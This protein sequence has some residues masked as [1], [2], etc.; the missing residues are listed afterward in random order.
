MTSGSPAKRAALYARVSTDEQAAKGTSLAGQLERCRTHVQAAGWHEVGTF[1]DEGVSGALASRPALDQVLRLVED[2]EIDIVVITKLDRIARSLRHLLD[3][4]ELFESHDVGLVALDDP[5]DPST[6]SGRAMVQLRGVFAELERQ[7]IRER[8]MEGMLR[9]ATAGGW[10]GG[11][12]P[13]GYRSVDNPQGQGKVLAINE[14]EA[15]VIRL[16]YELIAVQ[17]ATTSEAARELDQLGTRPRRASHWTHSNLRRLLKDAEGISG[18]WP[19]RRGGRQ[20]RDST[21]EIIVEIPSI[22]TRE[23]HDQLLAVLATTSTVVERRRPYLLSGRI[24]SPHGLRMQGVPGN[25]D[26]R[27]YQ[28]PHV[29]LANVPDGKKCGCGRVHAPTAEE[30]V[31]NQVTHLLGSPDSLIELAVA[32]EQSREPHAQRE[33]ERLAVLDQ[34]IADLE[35]SIGAQAADLTAEGLDAGA[36][37]AT[38]RVLNDRLLTLRTHRRDLLRLRGR[39]LASAG[40][41]ERLRTLAQQAQ[42]GLDKADHTTRTRIM[43]LLELQVDVTGWEPCETCDGKGLLRYDE[44]P[45]RHVPVGDDRRQKQLI[46]PDCLRTRQIPRMKIRGTV[47]ETLMLGLRE[48]EDTV[49]PLSGGQELPF[50]ADINVA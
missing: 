19:W 21:H 20:G 50:T 17:G 44:T 8:M 28:C 9:R 35:E 36:I 13:Y 33:R 1:V 48:D 26:H 14:E 2:G 23:E 7:L 29:L 49:V 43:D 30:A 42:R 16:A 10:L 24:V 15:A 12:P 22:L 18:R 25:G 27:W 46:C 11:P 37:A 38:V 40:V 31:W 4:L 3:L 45:R 34:Q 6:A 47:P 39:N 5:I 32:H 41:I